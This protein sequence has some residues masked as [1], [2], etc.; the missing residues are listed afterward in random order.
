MYSKQ[1]KEQISMIKSEKNFTNDIQATVQQLNNIVVKSEIKAAPEK[2]IRRHRKAKL[3]V[4]TPIIKN[5]MQNNK[6]SF[7]E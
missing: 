1:V 6:K 4:Y 2:K 7:R 5:A 3:A